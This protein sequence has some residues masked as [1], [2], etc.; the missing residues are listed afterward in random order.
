M[1]DKKNC[2]IQFLLLFLCSVKSCT[3]LEAAQP[4]LE[5]ERCFLC[6][7]TVLMPWKLNFFD[8]PNKKTPGISIFPSTHRCTNTGDIYSTY[9]FNF[10]PHLSPVC[11]W[12]SVQPSS[13]EKSLVFCH[14]AVGSSWLEEQRIFQ[15]W[16]NLVR[17]KC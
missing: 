16:Q 8:F 12:C 9:I 10:F 14:V 17:A 7:I 11:S 13:E 1:R 5:V 6:S 3:S 2:E 4:R 15:F